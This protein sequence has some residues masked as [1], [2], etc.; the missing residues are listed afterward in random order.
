MNY[1]AWRDRMEA[2]LEDNGLKAFI[3]SDIPQ[4]TTTNAQLIDA[5]KKNVAKVRMIVLK[6][7]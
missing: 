7:V 2:V 1:I 3:G 6:G 5:W 4:P